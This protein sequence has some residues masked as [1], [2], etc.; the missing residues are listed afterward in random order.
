[1]LGW[2]NWFILAGKFPDSMQFTVFISAGFL[3]FYDIVILLLRNTM[4][5]IMIIAT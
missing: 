2:S 3:D 4:D 5:I 1:M